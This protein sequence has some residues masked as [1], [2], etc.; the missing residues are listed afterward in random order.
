V[1]TPIKAT[2]RVPINRP[3]TNQRLPTAHLTCEGQ[4]VHTKGADPAVP[5]AKAE[6]LRKRSEDIGD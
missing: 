4:P 3:D 1:R 2:A 5:A 6:R